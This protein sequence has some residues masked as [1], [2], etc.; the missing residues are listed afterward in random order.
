M[1]SPPRRIA[2][3]ASHPIQ[4]QAPVWRRLAQ[5][6]QVDLLVH[7]FSDISVRGGVDPG[8]GVPIAWDQPL[9]E[10]YQHVFLS[11]S[12]GL[13]RPLEVKIP[14]DYL[15]RQNFDAALVNGYD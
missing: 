10:G 2:V 13:A 14:A 3:F 12:A 15:R 5:H 7:Y 4:Y 9:L 1:K 8:F 11:R 6:P